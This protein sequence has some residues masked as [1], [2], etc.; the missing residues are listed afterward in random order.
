M[1]QMAPAISVIIPTYNCGEFLAQTIDSALCQTMRP[2]EVIVVDDGSTDDT[3]RVLGA[4]EGRIR[5][6]RQRNQGVAVAR[7]RGIDM[8][9][10]DWL[11]FLDADDVLHLEALSAL[12]ALCA[13]ESRVVYGHRQHIDVLGRS[14]GVYRARDCTGPVPSAARQNFGG[15][16]FPPGC[17]IVP[18]RLAAEIRFDQRF[19]PCEDRDFWIRCGTRVAFH[20]APVEVLSYRDRPGSH[21]K[22]RRKQVVQSVRVRLRALEWFHGEGLSVFDP[23]PKPADVIERTLWDVYWQREWPIVDSLLDVASELGIHSPGIATVRRRRWGR[24]AI[25]LKDWFD[26]QRTRALTSQS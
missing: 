20:E 10:G 14:L 7:N 12:A 17:A 13:D 21:S 6:V 3:S 18:R 16:A 15:A 1:K 8:A 22:N 26:D 2:R 25:A 23:P 9:Q 19:A 24:W 11:M 5:V 4:L